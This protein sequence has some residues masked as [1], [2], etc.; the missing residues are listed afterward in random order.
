MAHVVASPGSCG[1]L[2]QGYGWGT[3]FM[4]TCPIDRYSRAESRLARS[5]SRLPEKSDLAR[6]LTLR[7]L[8]KESAAVDIHLTSDIPMGKG[9]ASSTAD[10]SAVCQATALACGCLL[11]PEEIA[12]IAIAIEPSDGTFYPGIV[13]FDYRGG[14]VLKRL[15]P[16]PAAKILV[17]D[18]GG[19]VDTLAFNVRK[20]L[21]AMQKENEE[22]IRRAVSLCIEGLRTGSVDRIGEAATI[23]A[24]ANQKIL[25]KEALEPFYEAG[26]KAGGRGVIAAHSGTVLGLLLDEQDD[27]GPVRRQ[28]DE[29]M[30]EQVSFIDC[31]HITNGGMTIREQ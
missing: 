30:R 2:I 22:E 24:F 3:S 1:E 12:A 25:Y 4:I 27:E 21:I 14:A 28:M 5:P 19:E 29:A 16:S 31:V 18:C 9:M 20:D 23:S 17:Y 8:G 7:Y 11:L 10:I 26:R 13:Q 6:E 15:G